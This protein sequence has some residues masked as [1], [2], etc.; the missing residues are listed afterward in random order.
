MRSSDELMAGAP[1]FPPEA[2]V[3][4]ANSQDPPYNDGFLVLHRGQ[5]VAEPPALA[6]GG[7]QAVVLAQPD[8]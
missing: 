3:T 7:G 2:Q 1:P 6:D 5:I 4:L 8:E